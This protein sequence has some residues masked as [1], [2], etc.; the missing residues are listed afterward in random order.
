MLND[1]A[2]FLRGH[3]LQALAEE[4]VHRL[5]RVTGRF[6][7]VDREALVEISRRCLD[8][9]LEGLSEP[10]SDDGILP[11]LDLWREF[12]GQGGL[13]I[14][15]RLAIYNTQKQAIQS[16]IPRFAQDVASAVG[17]VQELESNELGARVA[18]QNAVMARPEVGRREFELLVKSV[19]DYAIFMMSPE[20]RI[21][22]WNR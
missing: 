10:R 7:H 22:T 6:E 3:H 11:D 1:Y 5:R 13:T 4:H 19:S 8:G 15:D 16:Y 17:L 18:G 9:F 14:A 12:A 2:A 21:V 20:G